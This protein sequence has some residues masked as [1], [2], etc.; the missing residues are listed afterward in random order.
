MPMTHEV[1]EA[2]SR[3]LLVEDQPL[4][5]ALE[6]RVLEDAGYSTRVVTN[7][8][9]ALDLLRQGEWR[10]D[11]ILLDVMMPVMDGHEMLAAISEEP[12]WSTVP[13]IMMTALDD[14][15]DVLKAMRSGAVDYCTKPFDPQDL[16][17][18][19]GRH[20]SR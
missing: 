3:I 1:A 6:S 2:R 20:L 18:T 16:V 8:R 10:P 11:L 4:I 15:A 9:E 5:A 17:E 19:V 14:A 7:G 12:D 13:V